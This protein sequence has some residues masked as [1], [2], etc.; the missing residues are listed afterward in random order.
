MKRGSAEHMQTDNMHEQQHTLGS[1]GVKD[2]SLE[3]IY[4]FILWFWGWGEFRADSNEAKTFFVCLPS[5]SDEI[6][7]IQK[8][9]WRIS[10]L[11]KLSFARHV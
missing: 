8:V 4:S 10:S 11:T 5:A 3:F 9:W 2:S 7:F 1:Q 6:E